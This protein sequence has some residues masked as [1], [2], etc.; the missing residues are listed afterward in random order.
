M[1]IKVMSKTGKAIKAL[2]GLQAKNALMIKDGKEVQIALEQVQIGDV[3]IV[4]P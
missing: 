4:K 1:E 2:L 3:M